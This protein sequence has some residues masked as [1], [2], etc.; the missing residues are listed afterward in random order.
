MKFR[1]KRNNKKY[2]INITILKIYEQKHNKNSYMV[3]FVI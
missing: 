1:E 3:I 2:M